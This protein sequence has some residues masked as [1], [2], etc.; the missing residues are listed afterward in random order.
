MKLR[1][2]IPA[3]FLGF[4]GVA[5]EDVVDLDLPEGEALLVVDGSITTK[6][7]IHYLTVANTVSYDTEG[8]LPGITALVV[9]R[10]DKGRIDTLAETEPGSGIYAI[11]S[12]GVV[13]NTYTLEIETPDGKQYQSSPEFLAP[14]TEIDSIYLE[15]DEFEEDQYF[16]E[17]NTFDPPGFGN[18]YRWKHYIDG[19]FQNKPENLAF[20][21]DE[22][23]D[24]NPVLGLRL[25]ESVELGKLYKV[26]Q[27]SISKA[28]FEYLSVLQTQ[29][30]FVGSIFDP[31]PAP[32]EGNVFNIR[33]ENELVA[34]FFSASDVQTQS[35]VVR[36]P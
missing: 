32:I 17:F 3:L 5:C 21:S 10:D 33:D 36:E 15:E 22:F 26:E 13:G 6:D 31:P 35:I 12:P 8:A 27:L 9:L 18:Y 2:I 34:G 19:E 24:G 4:L 25:S 29:T 11:T 7:T 16:V 30:A 23:V 28:Y 1:Y 14:V 20:A